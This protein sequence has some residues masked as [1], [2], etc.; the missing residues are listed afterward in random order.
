V[1]LVLCA[2]NLQKDNLSVFKF[3]GLPDVPYKELYVNLCGVK[4]T[5][6]NA[7]RYLALGS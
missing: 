7:R 3:T 5:E 2:V 1:V 4:A 6:R